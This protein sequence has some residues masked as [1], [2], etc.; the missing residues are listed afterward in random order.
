MRTVRVKKGSGAFFAFTVLHDRYHYFE[1][2]PL[3][4]VS[5]PVSP[6]AQICLG[7]FC[8][9]FHGNPIT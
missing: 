7:Y 5:D 3:P 8:G 2:G 1:G 6:N 9:L 4:P